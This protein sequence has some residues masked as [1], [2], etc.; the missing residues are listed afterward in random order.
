[1][2]TKYKR[3]RTRFLPE[4]RFEIAPLAGAPFRGASETELERIKERLLARLLAEA[5]SGELY[6]PLR[7]AAN[8]AAALA[9]LTPF[10]LLFFPALL[11]E[12]V[13]GARLQFERQTV[14]LQRGRKGLRPVSA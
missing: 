14:I 6:A 11:E 12:K 3:V 10:P 4:T 8:D 5:E 9:W 13:V 7:R 1:M 2:N